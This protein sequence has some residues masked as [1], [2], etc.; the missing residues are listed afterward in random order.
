MTRRL[1]FD[2]HGTRFVG[3]TI[4]TLLPC[5]CGPAQR[6]RAGL[7]I[8][9]HPLC[10][11]AATDMGA[12]LCHLAVGTCG[13]AKARNGERPSVPASDDRVCQTDEPVTGFQGSILSWLAGCDGL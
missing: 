6:P 10:S 12:L 2:F 13:K 5:S 1:S 4:I 3:Q 11:T 8:P 9:A 7:V